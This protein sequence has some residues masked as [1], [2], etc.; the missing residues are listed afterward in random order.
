MRT[1]NHSFIFG[2]KGG[3]AGFRRFPR[4]SRLA[5]QAEGQRCTL[6]HDQ[7]RLCFYGVGML[8]DNGC[9]LD[10]PGASQSGTIF[11]FGGEEVV[12][13]LL[14]YDLFWNMGIFLTV[15]NCT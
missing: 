11:L 1:Y 14:R 13:G 2:G 4:G 8:W 12:G 3:E 9:S 6:Q 5:G 10:L 15:R 7:L